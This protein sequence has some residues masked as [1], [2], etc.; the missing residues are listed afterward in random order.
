MVVVPE[1]KPFENPT[2]S[3]ESAN[4]YPSRNTDRVTLNERL[5]LKI[6]LL[7]PNATKPADIPLAVDGESTVD[8]D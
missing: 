3:T 7:Q 8:V 5:R 4:C 6:P 1:F 2:F